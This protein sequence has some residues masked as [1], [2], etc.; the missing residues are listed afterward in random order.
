MVDVTKRGTGITDPIDVFRTRHV[1]RSKWPDVYNWY[2]ATSYNGTLNQTTFTWTTTT[3]FGM[4]FGRWGNPFT[5][6]KDWATASAVESGFASGFAQRLDHSLSTN[7]ADRVSRSAGETA[8]P[9]L[10]YF[11]V[12]MLAGQ[13]LRFVTKMY[14]DDPFRIDATTPTLIDAIPITTDPST[15]EVEVFGEASTAA[16]MLRI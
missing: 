6:P 13:Y 2:Y 1:Q 9:D 5:K 4:P 14:D 11:T 15:S 7:T 8:Q 16:W 10:I 3:P 12:T